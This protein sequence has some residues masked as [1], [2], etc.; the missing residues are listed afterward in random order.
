MQTVLIPTGLGLDPQALQD[1]LKRLHHYGG[2]RVLLLSVQP[3]YNGHVRRYLGEALV[4]AVIRKD[5]EREFS[6]WR[7]LLE[8]LSNI[9]LDFGAVKVTCT[10]AQAP[11]FLLVQIVVF[12]VTI[13]TIPGSLAI[14]HLLLDKREAN[15]PDKI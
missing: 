4:K 9:K 10:G 8:A 5:A 12:G 6:P 14:S 15:H 3:R 13:I 11:L 1:H 7:R 2:V